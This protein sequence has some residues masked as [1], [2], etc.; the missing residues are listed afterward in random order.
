MTIP[1]MALLGVGE[2]FGETVE[3]LLG[4]GVFAFEGGDGFFL[5]G[6][7][8]RIELLESLPGSKTLAP[9]LASGV[10]MYHVAYTVPNIGEAVAWARAQRARITVNPVPAVAFQGRLISFSMFRNGLFVEFIE[11]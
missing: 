7:G 6:G 9:W 3:D 11:R 4:V 8:P 5:V 2:A 1:S 10:R